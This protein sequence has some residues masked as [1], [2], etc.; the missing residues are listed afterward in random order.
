MCDPVE[1]AKYGTQEFWEERYLKEKETNTTFDW[2]K[3][4]ENL[5]GLFKKLIPMDS[6]ILH[7]GCGNSTLS[8]S[9]Y[10]Q[11]WHNQVNVD[12]S[13]A[14]IDMMSERTGAAMPDMSWLVADIFELDKVFQ[15]DSIDVAID[16]GTLDALLT[17]KHDP[18][19]PPK[20]LLD[21]MH[22]Y[23]NQVC[24][25]LKPNGVFVHVTFAQPHFRKRF[26]EIKE[27]D[28]Q[29]ETISGPT[30]GAIEYFAYICRPKQ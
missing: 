4:Y 9:M 22:S 1:N 3:G 8:E 21:R 15:Q 13:P 5:D 18:W 27:F 19:D 16:K 28:V 2:F 6:K 11:G 14:V 7:L 10:A 23:M 17:V 26:L 25:V 24:G 30:V 12:Y 29:V 20:D